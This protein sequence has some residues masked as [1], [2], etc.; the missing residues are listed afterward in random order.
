MRL[1][2]LICVQYPLKSSWVLP[3]KKSNTDSEARSRRPR[4]EIFFGAE[5]R[6]G[7]NTWHFLML[8]LKGA[9]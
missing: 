1:G 5:W 7:W 3:E 9:L 8:T 4:F 2:R 6:K